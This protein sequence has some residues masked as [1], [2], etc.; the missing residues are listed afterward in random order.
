M[1]SLLCWHIRDT[2][3][4]RPASRL[5]MAGQEESPLRMLKAR[6]R[7]SAEAAAQPED[8]RSKSAN[9]L[10]AELQAPNVPY[11]PASS[12]LSGSQADK[13]EWERPDSFTA[14]S[15]SSM[16]SLLGLGRP[17]QARF[18]VH[19]F[20]MSQSYPLASEP[21][22]PHASPPPPPPDAPPPLPL[23]LLRLQTSPCHTT[24]LLDSPARL[25]ANSS[26]STST[27]L[28]R[29]RERDRDR[30]RDRE[31]EREREREREREQTSRSHPPLI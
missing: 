14:M 23:P 3:F 22:G 29:E 21:G 9:E 28:V 25:L 19:H 11:R 20:H 8:K 12:S 16:V 17:G 27:P 13:T 1:R 10:A 4:Q 6:R 30:D 2:K 31:T 26:V 5:S 24:D 7:L 18:F 15:F